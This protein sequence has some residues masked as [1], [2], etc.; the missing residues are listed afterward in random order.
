MRAREWLGWIA[1]TLIVAVAVHIA[2]IWHLPHVIMHTALGKMGTP[3]TIHHGKR[4]DET[5]RGVVRPSPD[6]LY[7]ACPFDLSKGT[8]EVKAPIPAETYWSVSAFDSDT[9]NFFAINDR[10]MGGQPL[11][12][13]VLPPGHNAEPPHI[14][15]QLVIHSP[16]THGLIL[17]R[18]LVNDEKQFAKID[19]ERRQAIC[20][21][22]GT[23]P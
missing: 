8:L 18:T 15:G 22:L 4:P 10:R 7:S 17:F 9:N 2:S 6:L 12:L 11:E 14:A 16:S 3:N 1:A 13:L 20:G 5:A 21:I 23:R 19:A